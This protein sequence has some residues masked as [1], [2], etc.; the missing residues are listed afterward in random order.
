MPFGD[1][2]GCSLSALI[3]FRRATRLYVPVFGVAPRCR[4]CWGLSYA[5]QSWSYKRV[6]L[7]GP[8]YGQVAY[9][10]TRIRRAKRRAAAR[11]CYDARRELYFAVLVAAVRCIPVTA[12][13]RQG[14]VRP[15]A[16]ALPHESKGDR[17]D[18][19]LEL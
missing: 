19:R 13:R 3:A 5:S 8:L 9:A 11:V 10:T 15:S 14:Y 12:P 17:A 16:E 4:R 1:A 6:G 2:V 7:L 18:V